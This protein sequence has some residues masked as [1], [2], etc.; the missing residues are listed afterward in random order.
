MD[1]PGSPAPRRTTAVSG[2]LVA[3]LAV[4][5]TSLLREELRP[6]LTDHS[7]FAMDYLAIAFATWYG[8]FGPGLAAIVTAIPFAMLIIPPE[9]LAVRGTANVIALLLFVVIATLVAGLIESVRRA[10]QRA[11]DSRQRAI[12]A[13]EALRESRE[14]YRGLF[15]RNLAGVSRTTLDGRILE[16]NRALARIY[17][18]DEPD[19]MRAIPAEV[20]HENADARREFI[21]RLRAA[22]GTMVNVEAVGRRRDGTPVWTLESHQIVEAEGQAVIEG[23]ILDISDRKRIELDRE[24]LVAALELERQRLEA[25]IR[26]MPAGLV[27]ADAAGRLVLGNEQFEKIFGTNFSPDRAAGEAGFRAFHPDGR[28][29]VQEDW[30]LAR[31]L[32]AGA[33]VRDVEIA[34]ERQDGRRSVIV[35]SATPLRDAGGRIVAAVGTFF[36]VTEQ[37]AMARE[38]A[39]TVAELRE[40][41]R[42]KDEFIAMLAHELRNPL[43]PIAN[44]VRVLQLPEVGRG[45]LRESLAMIERQL[46]H[47]VRLV[48]DLLD[49]S[50]ISRGKIEIRKDRF[51]IA[52]MTAEVIADFRGEIERH[53]LAL[54]TSLPDAPIWIDGDRVRLA[55]VVTNLVQNAIKFTEKG[56]WIRIALAAEGDRARLC[57]RDSGI[58]I[59][60]AMLPRVFEPFSQADRSIARTRGGLGLGLALVRGLVSAHGGEVQA[61]SE[62]LGHGAEF[63]LHLPAAARRELDARSRTAR[64]G[65]APD[66]RVLVIEDNGPVADGMRFLL[67]HLGHHVRVSADGASGLVALRE[68]LPEIVLCDIGLPGEIDGYALARAVRAD[69]A[70]AGTCLIA[71]TGYGQTA[72]REQAREAGFDLH[73]T[74]PVDPKRLEEILAEP[75]QTRRPARR[76]A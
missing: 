25:V 30:P 56:G 65:P 69:P 64:T 61:A 3:V 57:V 17:G 27:I 38:L 5:I 39:R 10:R 47:M 72:D 49:V 55:E 11:V 37:R 45:T 73:L 36:E 63:I 71:L 21:E 31:A 22:G 19:A 26:Q 33:D 66:R 4:S 2:Y 14:K 28:P 60:P 74:K 70:V 16:A 18:Y 9:G 44:A 59:D 8:G 46:G 1:R 41:D 15:E 54:E 24:S 67:E 32:A 42:R 75:P 12:D 62:G 43:V 40:G 68:F 50:R 51:D 52:A 20:L 23:S 53:G 34:I 35:A 58:G 13:M 29:L 48:D 6:L 7:V 76:Q